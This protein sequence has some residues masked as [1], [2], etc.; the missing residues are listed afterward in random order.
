MG[1]D[2]K[3]WLVVAFVVAVMVLN[4]PFAA[5]AQ[6]QVP[7]FF[8]FGDSLVDNGNNNN[9]VSLAKANYRP[10]GIDFP[11]GTTGRFSNGKTTV[12]VIAELLGFDDYIPPYATASGEG[13]MKGVNYASAAA[14][15][16]D[17]TGRQ[18]GAR[19]SFGGQV[20]NYKNTVSQVVNILGNET[21]AANYLSKCIYSLAM[22]SNDYLNNYFMPQQYP[23]SRQ[24]TPA[25]YADVLIQQ[26]SQ[27]IRTLYNYGAR[28]L[29]LIGVGQIGCS[30]NA[31]AQNSRDGSTCV[32]R[33]NDANQMFN[34]RLRSLVDDLNKNLP[35]AKA[36][37]VNAYGIFQDIINSPSSFAPFLLSGT[38]GGDLKKWL[39]AF[40]VVAMVLNSP[41][42][43]RAQPQV[44]C[45]FIFGD[46]LVDNGNNNN[47]A[48]LARAN[49]RPY[50]IDFSAGPTGRFSN[51]KTTVDV[52]A[53]LLGFDDYIPPYA[54]ASGED[55]MKGVNYA[56]AAAGIRDETGRQ[57]GAR[58]SFGGQISNYKTTVSQVVNILGDED[59]AANYLSKCIYSLGMGSNDYLNNYFMPQNYPTSRQYTPAQYADV[60]VQQYSQQIRTLYNYGARKLVL[61]G[62]GQI[63][64]SP[65]SLAQNSQ[66]GSTCVQRIN[67]ANQMFNTRLKSLVDDL[68]NN[69]PDAKA[70]FINAYG[71]FQ[72]IISNPSSFGFSVT[73]AG[74]CG[75]GRNNGQITC[76]PFQTPCQDR[77]AYLFWDAFHPSE[78]ANI[79][80]GRRS[81]SAESSSDSYPVDIRRLAQL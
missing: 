24:Y 22:G 35:N 38:M 21:S 7:C 1:S 65:N 48:S 36:I 13:V 2:L 3:K 62:V 27:Q 43:A 18:L 25:Q 12:D 28:K 23:T 69:L 77:D 75:V 50:G 40:V 29:V 32:Q 9:I 14:G 63:G 11:A 81:Y 49:Y 53:E 26:Y 66:D 79:I 60:L 57:L 76:L 73:N 55:I 80:V 4:S 56:S 20:R 54:T 72:D 67:D 15:I 46:S 68:N 39:V 71:I 31:L 37:Y 30:P 74:C 6:P 8:I 58:I 78:A 19:I 10:Y 47:I 42:A 5:R 51:G 41:F 16:R 17:E 52:I 34:T 44:P 59:S 45:Y 64:C 33:I 61:I 70:I